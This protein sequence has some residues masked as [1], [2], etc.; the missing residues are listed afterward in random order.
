MEKKMAI[1]SAA[2]QKLQKTRSIQEPSMDQISPMKL[3]R[4]NGI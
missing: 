3:V 1:S 2:F 4:A